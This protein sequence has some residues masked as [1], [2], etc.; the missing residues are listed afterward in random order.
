M[1][2]VSQAFKVPHQ[3]EGEVGV[4]HPGI[5]TWRHL[6][7]LRRSA[8]SHDSTGMVT[9]IWQLLSTYP[10]LLPLNTLTAAEKYR[11]NVVVSGV[12]RNS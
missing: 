12:F 3:S 11:A 2:D 5:S 4:H 8:H 7:G 10:Q 6:S 9:I 1:L